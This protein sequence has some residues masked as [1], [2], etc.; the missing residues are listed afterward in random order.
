[1][2]NL[3]RSLLFVFIALLSCSK[4]EESAPPPVPSYTVSVIAGDGGTVSSEGGTYNQGTIFNVTATPASGYRFVGWSNG[5]TESTLTITVN[6][7]LSITA[8]EKQNYRTYIPSSYTLNL[9][10]LTILLKRDV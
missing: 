2:K 5:E 1:M 4:E 7:N 6:S 8:N 10:T 3:I 9:T